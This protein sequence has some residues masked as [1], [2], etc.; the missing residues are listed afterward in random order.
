M[1]AVTTLRDERAHPQGFAPPQDGI[2]GHRPAGSAPGNF[3][4]GQPI[5]LRATVIT[6]TV[7]RSVLLRM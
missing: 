6:T 3:R 7:R 2:A 1:R 5:S 4:T